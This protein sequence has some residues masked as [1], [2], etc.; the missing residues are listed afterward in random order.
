MTVDWNPSKLLSEPIILT[1]QMLGFSCPVCREF[2]YQTQKKIAT[3]EGIPLRTSS[4]GMSEDCTAKISILVQGYYMTK[5]WEY[6]SQIKTVNLK[7]QKNVEK[8]Q[9]QHQ[10]GKKLDPWKKTSKKK[11]KKNVQNKLRKDNAI[12]MWKTL[13]SDSAC[14]SFGFSLTFCKAKRIKNLNASLEVFVQI[15]NKS[16]YINTAN[17]A[18][19]SRV[20][21][22]SW[23]SWIWS[24]F[25]HPHH[26][27][28]HLPT[29]H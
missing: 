23:S 27:G 7:V 22:R 14:L 28:W 21:V 16:T 8:Y 12:N 17:I 29:C 9:K 5:V 1:Y 3:N 4:C 19:D 25:V 13:N 15:Y 10:R 11:T 20:M 2:R 6:K 26:W 24:S 18:K